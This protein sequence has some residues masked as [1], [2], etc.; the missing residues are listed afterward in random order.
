[1]HLIADEYETIL[2]KRFQF[3]LAN[4][5]GLEP[6]GF[7]HLNVLLLV[8]NN[9][10]FTNLA[11]RMSVSVSVTIKVNLSCYRLYFYSL[12]TTV[13]LIVEKNRNIL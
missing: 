13:R 4:F 2:T 1:M 3:F 6:K 7:L 9:R 8:G 10:C 5:Y 12:I 11:A